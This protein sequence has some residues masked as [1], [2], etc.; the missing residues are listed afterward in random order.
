MKKTET[1]K[2]NYEFVRIYKKGKFFAGKHIVAYVLKNR[3]GTNRLGITAN[4]KVGKSVKRNRLKR[5]I[6]E[7]YRFLEDFI[8]PG[9]D[10]VFVARGTD[11][12]IGFVEIHREM[13][14]LLKKLHA[15]DEKN[16]IN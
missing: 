6:R 1:L 16:E 14:F 9:L 4:K 2:K 12:E 11:T 5:L 15:F 8:P 10:I 13:K 3:F 7:S